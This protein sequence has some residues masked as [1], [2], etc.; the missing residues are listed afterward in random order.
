MG[1]GPPSAAIVTEAKDTAEAL[2]F[3][4]SNLPLLQ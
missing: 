3:D 1:S 2:D 4:I